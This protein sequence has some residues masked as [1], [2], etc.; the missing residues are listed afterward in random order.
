MI[1]L[2]ILQVNIYFLCYIVFCNI[3]NIFGELNLCRFTAHTILTSTKRMQ[4]H[5]IYHSKPIYN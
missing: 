3:S 4:N 5:L 2:Y 1:C